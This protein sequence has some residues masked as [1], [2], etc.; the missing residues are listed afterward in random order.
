MQPFLSSCRA[1]KNPSEP[2]TFLDAYR[3]YVAPRTAVQGAV[4]FQQY[5]GFHEVAALVA[6]KQPILVVFVG[7]RQTP[8]GL[9]KGRA[10]PENRKKLLQQPKP[11]LNKLK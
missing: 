6:I 4:W 2:S 11:T 3:A 5:G 10:A 1:L 7:D 8:G 9:S